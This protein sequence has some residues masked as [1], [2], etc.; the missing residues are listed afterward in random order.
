MELGRG[1]SPSCGPWPKMY[2]RRY[3]EPAVPYG[4]TNARF[5][6]TAHS[7]APLNMSTGISGIIMRS[8]PCCMR[9]ALLSMFHRRSAP[10]AQWC[11]QAPS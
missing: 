9:R 3:I 6:R 10:S 7:H 8:H 1:A 11:A 2:G 5:A 4:G